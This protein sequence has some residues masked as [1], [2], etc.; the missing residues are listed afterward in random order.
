MPSRNTNESVKKVMNR[1]NNF[2]QRNYTEKEYQ[3]MESF[4]IVINKNNE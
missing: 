3:K 2:P 4:L 1:F